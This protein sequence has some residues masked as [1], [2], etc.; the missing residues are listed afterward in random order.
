MTDIEEWYCAY[1][2]VITWYR[3]WGASYAPQPFQL[4]IL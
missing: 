3:E 4:I 1:V 2:D